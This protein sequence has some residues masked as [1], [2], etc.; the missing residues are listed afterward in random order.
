MEN[1]KETRATIESRLDVLRKGIISEENS[2]NYYNTLIDKTPEDS[3]ANIGMRRMY[4]DLMAEEKKHV[5]RF[6]ELILKWEQNLKE[7]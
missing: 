2:V 1:N 4:I 7:V 5:E 6:Q 3:E